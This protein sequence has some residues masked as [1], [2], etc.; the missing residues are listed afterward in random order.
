MPVQLP[1]AA[2]ALDLAGVLL[3]LAGI[4]DLLEI[5]L[6]VPPE[7]LPYH[8]HGWILIV[9][10]AALMSV[11]AFSIIRRFR[12]PGS[13]AKQRNRFDPTVQR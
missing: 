3:L 6:F 12:Q 7:T 10:G 9:A 8:G 2:L 1:L 5:E 11:A 4:F 13:A